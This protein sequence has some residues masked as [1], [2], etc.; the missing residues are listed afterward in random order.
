M[1]VRI[2]LVSI[3][4]LPLAGLVAYVIAS[5]SRS[6]TLPNRVSVV[7]AE[8]FY[9]DI[10]RQIGGPDVSVTS[11]LSNPNADPHLF[12]PG[13]SNGLAVA[14]ADLVIQNG[15]GYDAFMQ[16]LES[17]AP[18]KHRVVVT[19][20]EALGLHGADTNPHIWYDVPKLGRIAATIASGLERADPGDAATY[21]SG[22]ARFNASLRPLEQEL[23]AIRTR[24]A[25]EPVAYSEPVPGYLVAAAG[26][27]NLAPVAFTRAI[28]DGSEPSPQSVAQMTALATKRLIKV[29]LYNS[30]A[31]SPITSRIRAA[32]ISAGIPVIGVSETMPAGLTLQSWLLDETKTL[33]KAL[34]R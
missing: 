29:F 2:I 18:S 25:G 22:L 11:V 21:R 9:G 30:Q 26:L 24:F 33:A 28:E 31:V 8:N 6:N 27:R 23:S 10:A 17:A 4:S 1:R 15:L 7:A 16:R 20:S 13:T 32:V 19:I 14:T 12:E 3:I 34:S 5:G